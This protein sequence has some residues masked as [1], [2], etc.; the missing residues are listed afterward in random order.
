MS[1]QIN[2]GSRQDGQNVQ[3]LQR[4]LARKHR[5]VGSKVV[6][7]WRNFTPKQREK[8]MRES[9]G[10]GMALKH[11]R[12]R[13]LGVLCEYIPEYNLRDMTSKPEHF[14]NIFEFRASKPLFNQL[15]EGANGLPGDRELMEKTGLRYAEASDEERTIFLEGDSY[16]HSIQPTARGGGRLPP[17]PFERA[18]LVMIPRPIGELI[19]LRQQYLLQFLNHI[20]EE[21]LDLGSQTRTK[22]APE[23]NPQEALTTAFTNLNVQPKPLKSSLPEVLMQ[24]MES[25]A[26]L[27]DYLHLLRAEPVVLNQAVSTAY[28]GRAEL[29]PDDRGRILPVITD[30]HLSA[31]FFDSVTTAVKTVAIWDYILRLLQLLEDGIDKVKRGLIMQELSNICY[32]E[33]RRAQENFKRNVAPQAHVASK[34][35]KRMTDNASGQ[36]KIV[37]KGQPADCTVSDPQLHYILRLCHPDTSPSAAIQWIQKLDDHNVRHEDD[38]KKLDEAEAAA[39]GDLAIIVSFMHTTSTAISMAPLSRKSGLLFT[40][41][42]KELHDEL[43][44]LK[45]KADFGDYLIPIDN[46]LEPQM[47]T[48]ALAALDDF[49]IQGTGARLGSLYEDIVQDSLKDLEK[50]YARAKARLEKA[51]KATTYVPLPLESSPSG[52]ARLAYRRAKEKTRPAGS[53]VYTITAPPET[54]QIIITEPPQQ[55]KVKASTAS[56]FTTLFDKSEARGSVSWANFESAMADLEFSVTPKG[57][58]IFTLNPPASMNS[59]PMTLHRPHASEIEGYRLLYIASRLQRTYGWTSDSFVVT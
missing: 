57:G 47:A 36:S 31:A 16:G 3:G 17:P 8:A 39:L 56:V 49:I 9:I 32:L 24:A 50:L 25:K 21:I 46:L 23:K 5:N 22:K 19:V 38:R 15:Y 27:E 26:A 58:S 4:D 35:F 43:A 59:T 34:R 53:S 11:S 13:S 41:R 1:T 18:N 55:F 44:N 51:D 45:P 10:D 37:M 42:A 52:D 48:R 14:L 6:A 12:D 33:Y 40:A 54:P 28:W 2:H 29:V 30:R 7:I 20:V